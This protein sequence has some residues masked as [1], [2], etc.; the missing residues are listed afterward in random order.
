MFSSNV[1]ER[2]PSYFEKSKLFQLA[3]VESSQVCVWELFWVLATLQWLI[4]ISPPVGLTYLMGERPEVNTQ[5]IKFHSD[6]SK[7]KEQEDIGGGH[8]G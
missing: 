6:Y 5:L 3:F 7:E 1:F 2:N 4:K 8:T